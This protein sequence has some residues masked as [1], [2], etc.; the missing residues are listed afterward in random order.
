MA[1]SH[2]VT[3]AEWENFAN[4]KVFVEIISD[5]YYYSWEFLPL[6]RP[7]VYI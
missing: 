5:S 7:L 1:K 6:E 4:L 3:K 2:Y